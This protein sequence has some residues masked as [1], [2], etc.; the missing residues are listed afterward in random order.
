M[1]ARRIIYWLVNVL[2]T[3]FIVYIGFWVPYSNRPDSPKA[4][5]LFLQ[6]T[7]IPPDSVTGVRVHGSTEGFNGD[8]EQLLC[9]DYTQDETIEILSRHLSL[10]VKPPQ[11]LT[12]EELPWWHT[13]STN[14]E[15]LED[16]DTDR[17]PVVSA[18]IDRTTRRC[19]VRMTDS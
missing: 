17:S 18:W 14:L 5:Q 3:F 12:M 16:T 10:A 1:S 19:F 6:S 2:L 11:P 7:G 9:F 13:E 15:Y 4:K 8:W